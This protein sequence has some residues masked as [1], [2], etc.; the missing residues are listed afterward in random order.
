MDPADPAIPDCAYFAGQAYAALSVAEK[1]I[2]RLRYFVA[3]AGPAV[4]PESAARCCDGRYS[5]AEMYHRQGDATQAKSEF[6]IAR[7]LYAQAFGAS[8]TFVHKIDLRI[9]QMS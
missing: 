8:S 9:E 3:H 5:L 2:S 6:E 4:D 1:A 7:A